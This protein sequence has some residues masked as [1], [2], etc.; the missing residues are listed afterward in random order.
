MKI[1]VA[2]HTFNNFG[3]II[4]HTEQ[5][6][7]GFKDLGHK[8]E[9]AYIKPT[10]GPTKRAFD[11]VTDRPNFE[12]GAGSGY[13]V[14]QGDGWLAPHYSLLNQSSINDFV[15]V[16]NSCDLVIWQ[17]I[18]GF[19]Q[20][21]TEKYT[22]WTDMI[23]KVKAKQIVI[24]HDGNLKK[25]YPWI[26]RFSKHFAG[27]A[28]VHPSAFASAEFLPI[29]RALILNPQAPSTVFSMGKFKNRK[30]Q[31]LAP[32]TFKRW[33]RV[34]DLVAAV[35]Y[36]EGKV[37]V[38]GDG[39]ER[40]YM[41]SEDKCKPEYYC[42]PEL[43][44]DALDDRLGK[45]IWENALKCGMEYLGFITEKR[46]DEI[47]KESMFLL[48]PSWSKTYGEHFNR[49]IID[50]MRVG[51][52][53]I[54]R[55][56]GVSDNEDGIGSLLKPRENYLMIPY[57]VKPIKFGTLVNSYFQITGDR[58]E[59]MVYNN[60]KLIRRFN[61]ADIA[62]KFID[63]ANGKLETETGVPQKFPKVIADSNKMW[64]EHFEE[65]ASLGA[66]FD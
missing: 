18:F 26:S 43:D 22:A 32:Q 15:E 23:E 48:D 65:P 2:V 63:L 40:A 58:Y 39:M 59:E 64:E 61:R 52:V 25:L 29:P 4:N 45:R 47:L 21:A 49:S 20:K 37:L 54:A 8:V 41:A 35:P 30:K 27:V 13:L 50:A 9:F 42:T 10:K 1:L 34:D 44:P 62:Q 11:T 57:D 6:L 7:A 51:C 12:V 53:P 36:I 24:I 46:R 33:K 5:L 16:A 31:I 38:A 56:L 60:F 19:K 3:G 55:N 17:S 14:H 28:C 66:F